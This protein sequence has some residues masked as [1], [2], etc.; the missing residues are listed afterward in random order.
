MNL[1]SVDALATLNQCFYRLRGEHNISSETRS[2]VAQAHC[3]YCER[4]CLWKSHEKGDAETAYFRRMPRNIRSLE[5]SSG[6]FSTAIVPAFAVKEVE[7]VGVPD[8][9]FSPAPEDADAM[10][11]CE[12]M[13]KAAL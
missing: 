5:E 2:L 13:E 12:I 8:P 3:H 9:E 4:L 10:I 1:Q 11:G 7:V 6:D